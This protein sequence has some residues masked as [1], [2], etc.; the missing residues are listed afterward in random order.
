ME[1]GT[2]DVQLT[3]PPT[4]NTLSTK[5]VT[6]NSQLANKTQVNTCGRRAAADDCQDSKETIH[7]G[8]NEEAL[9][10][11]LEKRLPN[12]QYSLPT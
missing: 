9:R 2:R 3:D 12:A 4:Q 10:P 1:K 6:R 8:Q 11:E 7:I 5:P